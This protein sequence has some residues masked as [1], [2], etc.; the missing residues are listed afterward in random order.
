MRLSRC[1][2]GF[3]K[4]GISRVFW[5]QIHTY[6]REKNPCKSANFFKDVCCFEFENHV[7]ARLDFRRSLESGLRSSPRTV[8]ERRLI[9][10]TAAG[11]RANVKACRSACSEYLLRCSRFH[12]IHGK[13]KT[14]RTFGSSDRIYRGL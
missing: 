11:N 8:E 14:R 7:K 13:M 4:P 2:V 6:W 12:S 3:E 9:S 5:Y 1:M 10:R